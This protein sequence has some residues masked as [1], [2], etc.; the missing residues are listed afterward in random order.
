M[1]TKVANNKLIALYIYKL[2]VIRKH[3]YYIHDFMFSLPVW[4]NIFPVVKSITTVCYYRRNIY[5]IFKNIC[6]LDFTIQQ[7]LVT[8]FF[9]VN[10]LALLGKTS[11]G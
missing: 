4:I 1:A 7:K 10:N 11:S 8:K 6:K 9:H 2:K 3:N 5:G